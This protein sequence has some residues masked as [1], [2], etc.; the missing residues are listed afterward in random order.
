MIFQKGGEKVE[1]TI[2]FG[3]YQICRILG[4][5]R[6]GTVFLVRH[7]TLNEYRA[8]KR[9]S[10]EKGSEENFL[11]EAMIL[12]NLKHPGIPIIYDLEEDQN[13]YYLIE[14]YLE[15][16]SLFALVKRQGILTKASVISYGI[17]LCQIMD[18]LHSLKPNP[19][20]YLDLQPKNLLVC[21]GV[22]KLVDFDQ[23][24]SAI[25]SPKLKK[26]FGTIGYAAPEQF[27]RESLDV[28]TDVYAIG[29]ILYFMSTGT[30]PKSVKDENLRELEPKLSDL[31][32]RC[33]KRSKEERYQSVTYLIEDLQKL[34]IGIFGIKQMS[35]LKIA[36]ISSSHGMGATHVSFSLSSYLSRK[37][38]PNL[39][40]EKNNSGTA[41]NLASYYKKYPDK[42]GM[43]LVGGLNV[44]PMYGSCV[45]L[46]ALQYDVLVED[47]G[48]DLDQVMDQEDLETVLLVCG[49][50]PW[51]IKHTLEAIRY[52]SLKKE[53]RVIINHVSSGQEKNVSS[54]YKEIN[55][56][57]FPFSPDPEEKGICLDLFWESVLSKTTADILVNDRRRDRTAKKKGVPKK[58][59][60]EIK[61]TFKLIGKRPR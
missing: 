48:T 17:Q 47:Y 34:K 19:I 53:L 13:F 4:S 32:R 55:G 54:K 28:R 23:A 38:I 42:N 30:F 12:K 35:L 5:G 33:L 18:Y 57:Y 22:L 14:E 8:I 44:M 61:E 59:W 25:F 16:E 10:K 60:K 21:G 15:G 2:F 36:V 43:I 50:K 49:G 9:V 11:R 58:K 29:A 52:L 6:S 37:G 40:M 41:I 56:F 51:E 3:K 46:E 1:S 26:R 24:V 20:L 45:K 27:T 31:I 39:Y 7:I